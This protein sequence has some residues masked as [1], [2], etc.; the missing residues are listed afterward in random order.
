[1]KVGDLVEFKLP[2]ERF[3]PGVARQGIILR[4]YVTGSGSKE[5][6]VRWLPTLRTRSRVVASL[7]EVI[8]ESG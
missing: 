6:S 7:L 8:S 2:R 3:Y 1:M 4:A 5:Y